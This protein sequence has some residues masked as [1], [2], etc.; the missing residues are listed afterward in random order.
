MSHKLGPASTGIISVPIT[1]IDYNNGGELLSES[2]TGFY[3]QA[4][5]VNMIIQATI[6]PQQNSLGVVLFVTFTNQVIRLLQLTG[7]A[8]VEIPTTVGLNANLN[9]LIRST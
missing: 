2:A 7:G 8:L 3:P 1:I 4:A 6:A 5:P 9:I